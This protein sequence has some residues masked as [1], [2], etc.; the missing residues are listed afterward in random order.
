[1]VAALSD[2]YGRNS[3]LGVRLHGDHGELNKSTQD[4]QRAKILIKILPLRWHHAVDV[5]ETVSQYSFL[6]M[7]TSR[8]LF[9]IFNKAVISF[10]YLLNLKRH[11]FC[12]RYLN[13]GLHDGRC[14]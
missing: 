1:M 10:N 12:A 11:G 9:V 2:L 7:G 3:G 6:A 14:R 8:P 13:P 5:A 4:S